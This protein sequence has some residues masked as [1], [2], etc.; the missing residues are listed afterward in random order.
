ML[1]RY[2]SKLENVVVDTVLADSQ[3]VLFSEFA[4]GEVYVPDPTTLGTL[5]WYAAPEAGGT[6]YAAYDADGLAITHAVAAGRAYP[7]PADLAGA[8]A[9]KIVGDADGSVDLVLKG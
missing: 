4:L 6:Y 9:I 5:T 3:E 8:A 1:H 7:I 2:S